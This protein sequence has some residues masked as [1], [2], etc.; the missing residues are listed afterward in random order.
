MIQRSLSQEIFTMVALAYA[1]CDLLG[2]V[3]DQS[4]D[5]ATSFIQSK[6][7]QIVREKL[8]T[9]Q[10]SDVGILAFS[11]VAMANLDYRKQDV[12]ETHRLA[13]QHLVEARG[14][15]HNLLE[16]SGLVLQADRRLAVM[17]ESAPAFDPPASQS[18]DNLPQVI[19]HRYGSAFSS[20]TPAQTFDSDVLS[21]CMD[22]VTLIT[23]FEDN[24]ISYDSDQPSGEQANKLPL[25]HYMRDRV[26]FRFAHAYAKHAKQ[27]TL[28][29]Y[30]LTATKL[31]EYPLIY[32]NCLSHLT[33]HLA[34][35]LTAWLREDL[36]SDPP[37]KWQDSPDMLMWILWVLVTLKATWPTK[38]WV[39][40][41]LDTR[42]RTT[43]L[44]TP[45]VP[46]TGSEKKGSSTSAKSKKAKGK[47]KASDLP[48]TGSA[49]D[50]WREQ[51]WNKNMRW[52][53]SRALKEP[54]DRFCEYVD[55]DDG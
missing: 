8:E 6:L 42:L 7:A 15:V 47:E 39:R 4:F 13:L 26:S 1:K 2:Q 21:F 25:F 19:T 43:V 40:D 24:D 22:A 48:S 35:K 5:G 41:Q 20:N 9:F 50:G 18:E 37:L 46:S 31:V 16:I 34:S 38:A 30:V 12:L 10:P 33:E 11:V 54:F 49:Q 52:A 32:G 45:I 55:N 3:E 27:P 28:D 23:W 17:V 29:R 53:W 51:Q 36:D 14:G 44:P